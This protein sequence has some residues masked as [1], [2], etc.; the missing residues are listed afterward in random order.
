MPLSSTLPNLLAMA[1]SF[2]AMVLLGLLV[3]KLGGQIGAMLRWIIAGVF[4]SVFLHAGAELAVALGLLAPERLL[5]L[6]GLLL[7]AGSAA[8]CAGGLV[9]LRA[10][11]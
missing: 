2:A 10:L 5:P 7:S 9:G 6:M 1:T 11:R 4:L 8:F 3:P